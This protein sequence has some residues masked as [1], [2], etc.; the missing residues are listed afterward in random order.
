MMMQRA[1]DTIVAA[2]SPPGR[3][4]RGMV[5][6]CGP[7]TE[8]VL[9]KLIELREGDDVERWPDRRL[10][11]CRVRLQKHALPA[12]AVL[13]RRP[14]T[15]TG[16]DM[17]EL[18][19]AGHPAVLEQ[20]IH[21]AVALGARPA[22]AGEFTYRAFVAGK[23]DLTQA[24]GVAAT[25]AATSDSQLQAAALLRRGELGSMSQQLVDAL[26]SQIA[27]VEA[28]I[29]FVDQDDVTLIGAAALSHEVARI[30]GRLDH[31]L[32]HSRSWGALEALPRVVLAGRPSVGK[33]TL[34]N[35][36]LGRQRAV[37]AA[38]PGTTR[39]VLAEPLA[40][41][42]C[43]GAA[44][45]GSIEVMLVDMAGLDEPAGAL[46]RQMQAAA[47][48]AMTQ[49]DVVLHLFERQDDAA[50]LLV[51][52]PASAAVIRV[53]T[54]VDLNHAAAT[55][56]D[57]A[58]SGVTGVGLD[59]LRRRIVAA[60]GE[61]GVSVSGDMLALQPRHAAALQHARQA[62][63]ECQAMLKQQVDADA[64]VDAELIGAV[65]RSAMDELAALGGQMTPD[66]ILGRVFSTFCIGK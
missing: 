3:S 21:R 16:L 57:V 33:S 12:L 28:G 13:M 6:L 23:L 41:P 5:R 32:S 36:L 31:V 34:F 14:A 66:D 25:I 29:D 61:R 65:L 40:L 18:Q 59:E 27:L 52:A 35:A 15:A 44:A 56:C 2:S 55:D 4:L 8:A 51:A 63:A 37:M 30:A 1:D 22:E 45:S 58:V 9:G 7:D 38:M 53:R 17:G 20:L 42:Q 26:A 43:R 19:C 60:V 50:G 62:L 54:K 10:S 64:L 46:D 39:D 11:P 49:A 48:Q 24:E 47:Q